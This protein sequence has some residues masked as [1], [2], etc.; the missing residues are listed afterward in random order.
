MIQKIQGQEYLSVFAEIYNSANTLFEETERG[1]AAPETFA[2]QLENDNNY[3]YIDD[4][5]TICGFMSYYCH[6]KGCELT[7]LYVRS[8]WQRKGI[9][10][11]LLGCF[12]EQAPSGALLFVKAL[13][14][15]LWAVR[16]YTKHGYAPPDSKE[17]SELESIRIVEKPWSVIFCKYNYRI[18]RS[19]EQAVL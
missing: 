16:F 19:S 12:E 2:S 6:G 14:S 13:K 18:F 7:S 4:C 3:I 10:S 15:A 11:L 5:G 9:G 17:K 1:D 8:E